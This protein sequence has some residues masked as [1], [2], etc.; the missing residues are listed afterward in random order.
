MTYRQW[1]ARRRL[2]ALAAPLLLMAAALAAL[3]PAAG[4]TTVAPAA[5]AASCHNLTGIQPPSPGTTRNELTAVAVISACNTWA[6]GRQASGGD[7]QTL[8]EHWNGSAWKVVPSPNPGTSFNELNS[9]RGRSA[10]DVWAVGDATD[11]TK[12]KTLVLHW[13]GHTW[14]QVPSPSPGASF[15]VLTGVRTVSAHEAWAV[16]FSGS[17]TTTRPLIL[18]WN[19]T[20]WSTSPTPKVEPFSL[21]NGVAASSSTDVWAVGGGNVVSGPRQGPAARAH[22][23]PAVAAVASP[24]LIL[25]WNGHTWK[26]VPAPSPGT[27]FS[28]LMAVGA[29]SATSAWAVGE[30]ESGS[31][32]RTLILRWNGHTWAKVASPNPGG[33]TAGDGLSGVTAPAANTAWAVGFSNRKT[34]ILGWNGH[35]WAAVPSPNLGSELTFLAAVAASSPSN[36]WAV[37]DFENTGG[38]SQALALHCC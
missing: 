2:G 8:T 27:S 26:R 15:N 20:K 6:V 12:T 11:S 32:V 34:L 35:S 21:L 3:G 22:P 10:S 7:D 1:P 25:H 31:S 4:A 13:N 17:K 33:A 37:G 28:E 30:S 19:G 23:H 24:S 38:P 36:A 9:V 5:A 18:H 29:R 16:G 14:K